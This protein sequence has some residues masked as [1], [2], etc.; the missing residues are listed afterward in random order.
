VRTVLRGYD[1][2][3]ITSNDNDN[4][5]F[6]LP[7]GPFTVYQPFN[8]Q[9]TF[10]IDSYNTVGETEGGEVTIWTRPRKGPSLLVVE[11]ISDTTAEITFTLPAEAP[12]NG[13]YRCFAVPT[14]GGE[15]VVADA[16]E[17]PFLFDGLVPSTEYEFTA[18]AYN[19]YGDS[20]NNSFTT[21]DSV[22]SETLVDAQP[23]VHLS[24]IIDITG[25]NIIRYY[26]KP[27]EVGVDGWSGYTINATQGPVA[28]TYVSG[29]GTDTVL[30][31]LSRPI[32]DYEIISE[33]FTP[34]YDG[35]HGENGNFLQAFTDLGV[36]NSSDV[37][38]YES[39]EQVDTGGELGSNTDGYDS[40]YITSEVIN[41]S[42][43]TIDPDYDSGQIEG[44]R[45]LRTTRTTSGDA[46]V[47]FTIP[48]ELS[49]CWIYF[50]F[51]GNIKS[52]NRNVLQINNSSNLAVASFGNDGNW[53]NQFSVVANTLKFGGTER[54][55]YWLHY[56]QNSLCTGWTN[57]S[58][59]R[60]DGSSDLE[61]MG[62]SGNRGV[63]KIR[64]GALN[65]TNTLIF[66]RIIISRS[67]I[68]NNP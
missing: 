3:G 23:P 37:V 8:S 4:N 52:S 33:D 17:S 54:G 1:Y 59:I 39:F 22:I 46:Y 50:R 27:V 53:V 40:P 13:G 28:A 19:N 16:S 48:E 20:E 51:N 14:L 34:P 5:I 30:F 41:D 7:V 64:I 44:S 68:G 9:R 32:C 63:R 47:E 2:T 24:S 42:N 57:N 21:G 56:M 35:V 58:G 60:P 11:N 61:K 38:L 10:R 62:N 55:H 65:T 45:S 49:N 67:E 43:G 15:T 25:Y 12:A 29:V 18:V 36:G 26:N 31:R 6:V 66:D